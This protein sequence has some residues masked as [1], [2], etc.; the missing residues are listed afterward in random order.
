MVKCEE[1]MKKGYLKKFWNGF[2]LEEEEEEEEKED[3]K[4]RGCR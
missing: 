3:L 1:R 4:I 2:H